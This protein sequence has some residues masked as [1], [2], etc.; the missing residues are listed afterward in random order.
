MKLLCH[1]AVAMALASSTAAAGEPTGLYALLQTNKPPADPGFCAHYLQTN[2]ITP[3]T[4]AR[5]LKGGDAV[6]VH[7]YTR[8]TKR[9][10]DS[11]DGSGGPIK[12]WR[13]PEFTVTEESE[14]GSSTERYRLEE[15]TG[16]LVVMIMLAGKEHGAIPTY[17]CK[18]Q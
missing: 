14:D 17:Y 1:F 18:V 2:N 7:Q 15:R 12:G 8:I 16:G 13:G 9:R 3:A 5:F 11:T 6:G 10:L 4:A